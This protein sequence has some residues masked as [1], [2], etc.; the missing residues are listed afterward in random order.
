MFEFDE[1]CV[2][3]HHRPVRD[4]RLGNVSHVLILFKLRSGTN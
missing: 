2:V 4:R 1:G 3:R